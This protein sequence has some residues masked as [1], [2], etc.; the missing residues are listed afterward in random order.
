M[1]TECHVG[2][3]EIM[4]IKGNLFPVLENNKESMFLTLKWKGNSVFRHQS[5]KRTLG[6]SKKKKMFIL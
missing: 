2:D 1:K 6:H 4:F 3:I 5:M